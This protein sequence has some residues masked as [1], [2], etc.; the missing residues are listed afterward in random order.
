MTE[1]E[2]VLWRQLRYRL[3][4]GHKFRR[5]Q[6]LGPYIVDFICLERRVIIEV[7]G[8]Q[9]SGKM[10]YDAERDTWL[11]G[12]GFNI[13]RFWNNE[14]FEEIEGVKEVIARALSSFPPHLNPPPQ[15]GR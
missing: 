4:G 14:I 11:K 6:P 12:Q 5:Q 2:R 3:I 15:G 13:L 7:D 8:G 1:A 9:H 10:S